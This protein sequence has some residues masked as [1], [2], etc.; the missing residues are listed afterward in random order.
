[1]CDQCNAVLQ[2]LAVIESKLDRLVLALADE[3]DEGVAVSLDGD[4]V[5]VPRAE[6][7]ALS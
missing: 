1:M 5:A 2:R 7:V 6:G 3:A 4:S